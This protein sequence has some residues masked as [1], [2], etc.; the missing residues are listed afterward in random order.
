MGTATL[1]SVVFCITWLCKIK[2]CLSSMMQTRKPNSTG[3]PAL[4][5]WSIR[6][7]VE[8][9]KRPFR[10]GECF[11]LNSAASNLVDLTLGMLAKSVQVSKQ[12]VRDFIVV[13]QDH[14]TGLSALKIDPCQINV[15]L[16][17]L[18]YLP[19]F[20][21]LFVF[22]FR[23]RMLELLQLRYKRL[24]WRRLLSWF[25]QPG[26]TCCACHL[27]HTWIKVRMASYNKLISVGK[28]TSVFNTNE[29]QRPR[30]MAWMSRSS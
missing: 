25:R 23:G 12:Y 10:H 18:L 17:G 9:G 15:V 30:I 11:H 6:C 4:P 21:G 28:C 19:F 26:K 1:S 24:N 7:A 14:Y 3:T 5:Y 27:A 20:S 29:S 13:F 2:P 22:V 8:T 16:I